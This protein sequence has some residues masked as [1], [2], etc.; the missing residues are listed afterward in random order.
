MSFPRTHY[1]AAVLTAF[2]GCAP[3]S[4]LVIAPARAAPAISTADRLV[5]VV[6]SVALYPDPLLAQVF[7]AAQFPGQVAEA[8]RWLQLNP[9][10][11]GDAATRQAARK[12]W[13]ASV[14]SLVAF[15]DVLHAMAGQ[16]A[17]LRNLGQAYA[18]QPTQV[19]DA[20]QRLRRQAYQAGHLRTG[21]QQQVVLAHGRISIEPVDPRLVYVPA[22]DPVVVYGHWAYASPPV[23]FAPR[24]RVGE[25][26]AAGLAFG[27]G[28]AIINAQWGDIDWDHG[29]TVVNHY[30]TDNSVYVDDRST[31]VDNSDHSIRVEDNSDHSIHV[32]DNSDHSN[33]IEDNSDHSNHVEDNSDHV[34]QVDASSP[35]ID[36][37]EGD[38]GDDISSGQPDHDGADDTIVGEDD[39]EEQEADISFDNDPVEESNDGFSDEDDGSDDGLSSDDSD[40]DGGISDDGGDAD[41]GFS[42]DEDE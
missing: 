6:A 24:A 17:W 18:Q 34:S 19:M 11:Q 29:T 2:L 12:R 42:G 33:H 35:V 20:V 16:P 3:V 37:D 36:D 40:A 32:E 25:A 14:Q 30:Y 28:V 26:V 22:Y 27:L 9:R 13:N 1:L 23:V 41:S 39:E 10:L 7:T 8:S 21:K 15:P 4:G 5:P 38:D 31:H